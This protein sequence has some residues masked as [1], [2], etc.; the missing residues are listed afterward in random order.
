VWSSLAIQRPSA[1]RARVNIFGV[2]FDITWEDKASN[3]AK[4]RALVKKAAPTAES[5]VV[6]PEM[7][8]TGFS[9][10]ASSIAESY[11]GETET[12]L[13]GVAREHGVYVLAGAAVRG[14]DSQPRNKALLFSP[15]GELKGFYAKMRPFT[16]GGEAAHYTAGERAVAF[17]VGKLFMAPLVCYDLRFPEL[18]RQVAAVHRPE[19]FVVIANWPEKRIHHWVRLLQARA[20][21]NQAYVVGVNRIGKDPFYSY[22]G[23][24]LVVD[25]NGD[26]IADG[27]DGESIVQATLDLQSLRQYR[28]G[29]P[30]LEDLK[31]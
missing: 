31:L 11:Q 28:K 24:S 3:F 23:R 12:F 22:A 18:F 10:N 20:I 27:Q 21:E 26:I 30:F 6:L 8:A 5:L 29:L 9:M 13:S 15:N 4:V 2:Q 1:Y 14:K 25:F 17:P 16:P 7:F 19:L